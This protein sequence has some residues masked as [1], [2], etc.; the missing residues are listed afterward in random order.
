MVAASSKRG[1][2]YYVGSVISSLNGSHP[3]AKK[4]LNAMM[5]TLRTALSLTMPSVFEV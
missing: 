1:K 3:S 4:H 2:D 5:C